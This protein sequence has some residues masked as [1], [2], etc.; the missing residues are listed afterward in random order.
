M[1]TG[2]LARFWVG[3][4]HLHLGQ[5]LF[6]IGWS[7]PLDICGIEL[8]LACALWFSAIALSLPGCSDMRALISLGRSIVLDWLSYFGLCPQKDFVFCYWR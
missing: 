7:Q 2:A 5:D 4:G 6:H 8:L 1:D 3:N